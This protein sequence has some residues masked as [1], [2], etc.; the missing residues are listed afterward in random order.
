MW[1]KVKLFEP[2]AEV[3]F[4]SIEIH[5]ISAVLSFGSSGFF[6]FKTSVGS[7]LNIFFL[8]NFLCKY[9]FCSRSRGIIETHDH[10]MSTDQ[11]P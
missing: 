1:E 8:V 11:I 3:D 6:R 5:R 10:Q 9:N 2:S 4:S 7:F